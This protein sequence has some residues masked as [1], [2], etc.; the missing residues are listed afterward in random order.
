MALKDDRVERCLRSN[1]NDIELLILFFDPE[2]VCY[3]IV[4]Y[5]M[6]PL[7]VTGLSVSIR[8]SKHDSSIYYILPDSIQTDHATLG[9]QIYKGC[10]YLCK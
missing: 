1:G 6:S 9:M 3:L 8:G 7:P 5:L 4:S 2:L 10:R